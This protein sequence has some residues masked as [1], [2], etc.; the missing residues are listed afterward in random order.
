MSTIGEVAFLLDNKEQVVTSKIINEIVY[1]TVQERESLLRK[2]I[3]EIIIDY[4]KGN[5]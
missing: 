2:A 1:S 4:N 3:N 5:K